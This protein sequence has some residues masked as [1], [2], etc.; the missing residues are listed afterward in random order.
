M[1]E[2]E[3]S[4]VGLF[5]RLGRLPKGEIDNNRSAFAD[6]KSQKSYPADRVIDR[7]RSSGIAVYYAI[8]MSY[9]CLTYVSSVSCIFYL[10][11]SQRLATHTV[12]FVVFVLVY[13]SRRVR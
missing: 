8:C 11:F 6:L 2:A 4:A 3:E 12:L 10:P 13:S 9:P 5:G 1:A 7:D